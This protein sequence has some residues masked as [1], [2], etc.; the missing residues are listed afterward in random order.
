MVAL[1]AA[2]V[3][4]GAGLLFLI[5]P[6]FARMVLPFLGGSPAVWNT[7]MVFYQSA[8]LA[9]YGYAHVST[10]RL[11]V[12]RQAAWHLVLLAAPLPFL[13]VAIPAGWPPPP[14]SAPLPWLLGVMAAAV[15]LPFFAIA[16]TSPLLQRWFAGTCHPR[17]ADPYFLFVASNAGSL[18]ALVSYPAWIE[19]YW[20]L[21]AQSRGWMWA[22]GLLVVLTAACAVR[23]WRSPPAPVA[24]PAGPPGTDRPAFRRRL[25]WAWLAFVPSSLLLGVTTFFSA[26]IVV[27]P[28]IWVVPLAIYLLTFILAFARRPLLS[29]PWLTRL[30]P[31]LL[32]PLVMTLNL[33]SVQ[34]MAVLVLLHLAAFFTAA[35]LCHT[36]LAADRP[37]ALHLTEFYL[38]IA[39]GGALGGLF[40]ALIAPLVFR[41]VAEYPLMLVLAC[42]AG[43]PPAGRSWRDLGRDLL[44]PG[45][46]VLGT[47]A[48]VLAVHAS[49][50]RA[51]PVAD[52]FLFG[53]PTLGCFLFSRRPLRFALG[54]GGLLFIGGL[55]ETDRGQLLYARR[56]FFGI[57][58]VVV[59]HD[60]RQHLLSNGR[61]LHGIQS[62][63]PDRRRE[64]LTYYARSGP[65]GDVLAACGG[66]PAAR[67]GVVG[68]GAGTLAAYARPGQHW[69]YFEIDPTVLQIARDE[70]FFTFLRDA[71]AP[72]RVVLGDARLSLANEPDAAYDLLILDA[73]SSDAIPVHLVTREA[74]ALYLRKLAPGG[75]LAF[76]ISTLHVDLEPVLAGLARDAGLAALTRADTEVPAL[77]RARGKAPSVWLV[78][79]RRADDLAAL[80]ANRRWHPS[81]G[82]AGGAVWTDDYSSVLSILRWR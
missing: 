11:G 79:A 75:R 68:L 9:A 35:A 56:T 60:R 27:V 64:P 52:G 67:I 21:A 73:Y 65:A 40:N 15:G 49:P 36:L 76:H 23:L 6:L 74:L 3:F 54:L 26:D 62:L 17:A 72:A 51:N 33:R 13:P 38:W 82:R 19:P 7:A 39:V 43:F 32:A 31:L 41:S 4:V 42:L 50:L 66:G 28:L 34:P 14:P 48:A 63:D 46:L 12:R 71:A 70:R 18:L 58:R 80:A 81:R 20:R 37:P 45:L 1:Y 10:A 2:T 8:L 59:D 22:Y 25:R 24:A 29:R 69:S 53:A 77:E 78:M 61:I 47:A 55:Y 16:A 57:H 30:L 5:Q 44:W